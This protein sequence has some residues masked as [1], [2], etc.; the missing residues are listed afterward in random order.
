MK[1]TYALIIALFALATL[2][3]YA[4]KTTT[5]EYS[6]NRTYTTSTRTVNFWYQGELNIGYAINS[7]INY[8]EVDGGDT[9]RESWKSNFS[10]PFISTT[11][12]IRIT[13]W[14]YAGIGV[15][16]HYAYG[17]TDEYKDEHWN[18]LMVPIFFNVK[19][20]Y[21]VNDDFSV[22]VTLSFG[23]SPIA[24]SELNQQLRDWNEYDE[25]HYRGGYYGEYGVGLNYKRLNF[26]FG[27]QQQYMRAVDFDDKSYKEIYKANSFY[28]KVG[29]MF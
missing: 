2:S 27:L 22:Y 19:G 8:K 13:K 16:L 23:D 15:G 14:A 29:L 5:L 1:K 12:G 7:K 18:T 6:R 20:Y 9:Y 11:H 4:Q 17:Y 10:Q 3:A 28:L 21:P 26:S 25:W 24:Y